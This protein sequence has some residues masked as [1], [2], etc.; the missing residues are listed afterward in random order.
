MTVIGRSTSI[1]AIAI[2]TAIVVTV[3]VTQV[4]SAGSPAPDEV[5]SQAVAG[6]TEEGV[7]VESWSLEGTALKVFLSSAST[8]VVGTPDDPINL[9]LVQREAFLAKSR[10]VDLARLQLEVTN[11]RGETLFV[12]DIVMD[13]NLDQ[14]WSRTEALAEAD[15]LETVRAAITEKTDLSGL[16]LGPVTLTSRNGSRVIRL[17]AVASDAK[18]AS[19]ST[20][21]LMI[22]IYNAVN[23]TNTLKNGQVALAFV[24]ITGKQGEPLLKWVYDAQ[25]GTQDWWQAPGMT[26]DWFETPRPAASYAEAK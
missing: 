15:T 21:S 19:A 26:T 10:G 12:G 14:S 16:A 9:S 2:I 24:D 5:I 17:N 4:A 25:R 7:P 20:A 11:A 22:S 13:R 18:S 3:A 23:D 1:T 8:G 6:L